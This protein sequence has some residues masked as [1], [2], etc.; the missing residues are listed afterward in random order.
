[1]SQRQPELSV[2]VPTHGRPGRIDALLGA[3]ARQ[4]LAAERFEAVVVDDGSPEP[5][6]APD[7]ARTSHRF[8]LELIRQP[9]AGPGAARNR[10]FERCHAPLVLLLNDD[11]IPASDLLERHLAA[12]ADIEPKTALLGSFAFTQEALR[13]PFVRVLAESSLLFDFENL[14]HDELHDWRFF[15]SCNLSMPLAPILEAGGY[16]AERFPEALMEDVELGYRLEQLGWRLRFRADAECLHDHAYTADEYFRRLNRQ[17][18]YLARMWQKHRDPRILG[19][20]RPEQVEALIQRAQLHYEQ[21]RATYQKSREQLDLLEESHAPIDAATLRA[22]RDV[23]SRVRVVPMTRGFATELHGCDPEEVAVHGAQAGP[24]TSVILVSCNARDDTRGCLESLRATRDERFPMEI[25]V[26]DNG[27]DDGSV[28]YLRAQPDVSLIEN[29]SNEGAPRARNQALARTRGD[30]IVVLDND[31]TVYPGWLERLRYH[32]EIDPAVAC[33]VPVADRA[34][35]GQQ[36]EAPSPDDPTALAEFAAARAQEA[37]RQAI[38]CQ[39][40]SSLCVLIRADVIRQIGGF[41]ERFSP[42]GFEDDDFSLRVHLAG[43]RSRMALDVF[44][45]HASYTGP[46]AERHDA[47]LERNWQRFAEKWGGSRNH[48]YGEYSF[49]APVIARSWEVRS[50]R[51]PLSSP[52][53]AP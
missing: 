44:V 30:W 6:A 35:H 23:V 3:L 26:V 19:A 27:S 18:I 21:L 4:T 20:A 9:H 29:R 51:V 12:Q 40:F 39:I 41:D 46:K 52:D 36:I 42:W 10:A 49:L 32:A 15:R 25:L 13:R 31:V 17:G 47:L 50:L 8:H 45:H 34:A 1:M 16:D 22:V 48:T 43:H 2:V 28:E 11:V 7:P 37:H 38:Y 5:I 14:K 24:L 33:V 53:A